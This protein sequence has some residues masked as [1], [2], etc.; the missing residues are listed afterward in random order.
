MP[1][2]SP[3]AFISVEASLTTRLWSTF[4]ALHDELLPA[5]TKAANTGNWASLDQLIEQIDLEGVFDL[6]EK[7]I[8]Y[9]SNVAMLFGATRA[10]GR[11]A[12]ATH[13]GLGY[14]TETVDQVMAS[15]RQMLST[16]GVESIQKQA[17]IYAEFLKAPA[18]EEGRYMGQVMKFHNVSNQPRVPAGSPQGG[19]FTSTGYP[20]RLSALDALPKPKVEEALHAGVMQAPEGTPEFGTPSKGSVQV[21]GVHYSTGER[22]FLSGS[23]HGQGLK[24]AADE[25]LSETGTDPRL[26]QRIYFYVDEGHG[27]VPESGVGG[28]KHVT[29]LKNLYDPQMDH[30]QVWS[31]GKG[32][33]NASEKAVLDAGYDGYYVRNFANRAGVA[34]VLGDKIV[35]TKVVKDTVA[36]Y[37]ENHDEKGRFASGSSG[38][39]IAVDTGRYTMSDEVASHVGSVLHELSKDYPGAA[40]WVSKLALTASSTNEYDVFSKELRIGGYGLDKSLA[41]VNADMDKANADD[42]DIKGGLKALLT[43][44]FGHALDDYIKRSADDDGKDAWH[45][46]KKDLEKSLGAPSK[47]GA[48]NTTEWFAE[49]F[50]AERLGKTEQVLTKLISEH[51][52]SAKVA[53]DDIAGGD[54]STTGGLK[55]SGMPSKYLLAARRGAKKR[56]KD[57]ARHLGL[58][59]KA[60]SFDAL[61]A[62]DG[63]L[64]TTGTQGA[65]DAELLRAK[66]RAPLVPPGLVHIAMPSVFDILPVS[67]LKY[68]QNHDEKGR[69]ASADDG[70]LPDVSLEDPSLF[71]LK[72]AIARKAFAFRTETSDSYGTTTHKL[73]VVPNDIPEDWEVTPRGQLYDPAYFKVSEFGRTT[74]RDDQT[75]SLYDF[76]A[77]REEGFIF[78]GMSYEEYQQ[79][80]KDGFFKSKGTYNLGP[81]QEGLTYYSKDPEQASAYASGFAPWQYK[82]TPTRP[83]VVVKVKD[84]GGHV[85]VEGTG[86][87]EVGLKGSLSTKEVSKVYF[88][89]AI[90][91]DPGYLELRVEDYPKGSK[92]A[93]MGSASGMSTSL[94]WEEQGAVQKAEGDPSVLPFASFVDSAGKTFFNVASSLHTS[95][96]SAFGYTAEARYLGITRYQVD[97]QLD[98][99]TC[100]VCA[101]MNGKTFNVQA[102]RDFLDVVVRTE[103]ADELRDLQ[104]WPSQSKQ[105]VKDLRAMSEADLVS[106]GWHVPPYHPRCR[107]LLSK[108]KV[109]TT[110]GET[111]TPTTEPSEAPEPRYEATTEDFKQLGVTMTPERVDQWN[112][113]M[114]TSPAD[115]LGMLQGTSEEAIVE[116]AQTATEGDHQQLIRDALGITELGVNSYGAIRLALQRVSQFHGGDLRSVTMDLYYNPDRNLFISS[117]E[118]DGTEAEVAYLLRTTLRGAYQSAVAEGFDTMSMTA[119]ADLSGYALAKYGLATSEDAWVGLKTQIERVLAKTDMDAMLSA[120]ERTVLDAILQSDDPK[121]IFLLSDLPNVGEA[122]LAGT[123]WMGS[124]DLHDPESIARFLAYIYNNAEV[125]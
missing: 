3:Q 28:Y 65:D 36:K 120:N 80:Q 94:R 68:N 111:A 63:E 75:R 54:L 23:H 98:S 41:Q 20:M 96:L 25:R 119:G 118:V 14:D 5:M 84:P 85:A 53:K 99:R 39:T 102:A 110:E 50:T 31:Q 29:L 109:Q 86:E 76:P 4:L 18:G 33:A 88:G 35:P 70:G 21:L 89:H 72:E 91:V 38:S 121:D 101:V 69:F 55:T 58:Q 71:A 40:Q 79:A 104:P 16:T 27:I 115:L 45:S 11:H 112:R 34:V 24:D 90:A 17:R 8:R 77:K 32:N 2:V 9:M 67:A 100:D 48:K 15:F 51:L 82:A 83:A 12:K 61:L 107:G 117:V 30:G 6:N 22:K 64:D 42:F 52:P 57:P 123:H 59:L 125:E 92:K 43:H 47:Y 44:E 108:A 26:K 13:V 95:R 10:T 56:R 87:D 19:E 114:E 105:A 124:L 113:L 116:A 106:N 60:E 78:R 93:T 46:A 1:A 97:E 37:N 62:Q 122:L 74:L 7:Y 66:E 49:R 73:T 81:D 103:D